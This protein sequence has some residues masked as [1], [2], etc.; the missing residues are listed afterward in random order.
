MT[1][2]G[3]NEI[4]VWRHAPIGFCAGYDLREFREELGNKSFNVCFDAGPPNVIRRLKIQSEI[5]LLDTFLVQRFVPKTSIKQHK[6]V[7]VPR[8]E[9]LRLRLICFAIRILYQRVVIW[10]TSFERAR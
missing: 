8:K 3:A 9:K 10:I 6:F 5:V 1:V 7:H 2:E 4:F